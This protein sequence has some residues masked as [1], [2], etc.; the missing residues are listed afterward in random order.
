VVN[1]L[2]ANGLS[3]TSG[4]LAIAPEGADAGTSRLNSLTVGAAK[5]TKIGIANATLFMCCLV[6]VSRGAAR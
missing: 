3:I 5:V 1:N 6:A 4:T 2:R